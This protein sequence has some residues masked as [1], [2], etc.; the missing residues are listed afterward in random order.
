MK[1]SKLLLLLALVPAACDPGVLDR[2]VPEP[3]MDSVS[4]PDVARLLSALP[5]GG[6]QLSEVHAAVSASSRNGY[7]EE[8]TMRDLFE[9]P[10]A[11]VGDRAGK[12]SGAAAQYDAPLRSLIETYVRERYRTKAGETDPEAVQT[13]LDALAASDAQIYWPYSE[14]YDGKS[15]PVITFDPGGDATANV[16][17]RTRVDGSG[18]RTVEEIVV[19]EDYART[20][21]VWVVNNNSDSGYASLEMRRRADPDWGRGGEVLVKGG[22][23]DDTENSRMLVLKYFKMNRNYDSWFGGASEFFVKCGSMSGFKAKTEAEMQEYYP[24]IT[25]FMI[26]VKRRDLGSHRPFN[27]ILISDWTDQI[28][29]FCLLVTEDDGGTRTSWKCSASA[30]VQSKSY[31]FDLDIPYHDRDDIVWRGTLSRKF[32]E[33]YSGV[34]GHF[35]DVE[36]TFGII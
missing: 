32:F 28:E 2:E 34:T 15:L 36:L 33:K 26:V 4:L 10:G 9:S 12:G 11:G 22:S 18:K 14:E 31:G 25:D 3:A 29:D 6:E 1:T 30:K 19:D 24:T 20:H 5:I 16:G 21:P 23:G 13:Y 17:Y 8:Y 7:D 27:A 35:G